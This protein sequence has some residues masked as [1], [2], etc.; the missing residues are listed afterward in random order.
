M[1][2]DYFIWFN[3]IKRNFAFLTKL[4][5]WGKLETFSRH[6]HV[7]KQVNL[8]Y[9]VFSFFTTHLKTGKSWNR[10]KKFETGQI[11]ISVFKMR[12]LRPRD[13]Q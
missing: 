8:L 10:K 13:I 6:A 4:V 1:K 7:N 5:H 9:V 3:L 11:F 2:N 12:E